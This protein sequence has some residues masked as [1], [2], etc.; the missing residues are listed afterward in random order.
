MGGGGSRRLPRTTS[1]GKDLQIF[2]AHKNLAAYR[3]FFLGFFLFFRPTRF[4]I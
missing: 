2:T 1:F 4:D 3:F